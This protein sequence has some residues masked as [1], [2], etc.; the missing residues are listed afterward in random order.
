MLEVETEPEHQGSMI[1]NFKF[2]EV[3]K[4]GKG[5]SLFFFSVFRQTN[6]N[7]SRL[8]LLKEAEAGGSGV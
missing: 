3:Q 8:D 5:K 4:N 7:T 2:L 6:G 1:L